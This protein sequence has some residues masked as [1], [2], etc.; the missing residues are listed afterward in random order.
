[1]FEKMMRD[2]LFVSRR[3]SS[4]L[5]VLAVAAATVAHM[6]AAPIA[7]GDYVYNLEN[8][9]SDQNGWSVSGQIITD[10][11]TGVIS[12][13]DIDSWSLT[14]TQG[15]S[16]ITACS[17]DP[18]ATLPSAISLYATPQALSLYLP[19]FNSTS[20]NGY[21]DLYDPESNPGPASGL[22]VQWWYCPSSN[23]NLSG[24][25]ACNWQNPN[26]FYW[27]DGFDSYHTPPYSLIQNQ[28]I[29]ATAAPEPAT[30]GL[31]VTALFGLGGIHSFRS[32]LRRLRGAKA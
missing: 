16:I 2:L 4:W 12:T 13:G 1:M 3:R 22:L 8:Y 27:N 23:T 19:P 10:T 32:F 25:G 18:G 14:M 21:F 28:Y 7:R 11:N 5:A 15:A 24:Y 6:W 17:S 9:L 20:N 31:L 26:T 30:L 29:M